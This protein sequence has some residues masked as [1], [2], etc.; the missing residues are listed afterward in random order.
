MSE[1]NQK[2][3][4]LETQH[5]NDVVE[6]LN[7]Y[8]SIFGDVPTKTQIIKHDVQLVNDSPRRQAPYRVNPE[9]CA[10]ISKEIK[11]VLKHDIIEPS[12]SRHTAPCVLVKNPDGLSYRVCTD[13]RKLNAITVA[14]SHSLPRL[15]YCINNRG[16]SKFVS[17]FDLL[18]G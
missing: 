2:L 4:H 14:D 5:S 6:L 3:G 11:Y 18:K 17:K 10:I 9:K 13:Y 15:E 12:K 16:H 7:R 8:H 1:I